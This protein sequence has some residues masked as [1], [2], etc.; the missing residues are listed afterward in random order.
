MMFTSVSLQFRTQHQGLQKRAKDNGGSQW[1]PHLMSHSQYPTVSVAHIWE[2]GCRYC[3]ITA[4][5]VPGK[6]N[7]HWKLVIKSPDP[8]PC[9]V[10]SGIHIKGKLL[11]VHHEEANVMIINQMICEAQKTCESIWYLSWVHTWSQLMCPA[12]QCTLKPHMLGT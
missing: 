2:Q 1:L 5:S 11:T 8:I 12:L 6:K 10:S 4:G 9:E 3:Q 7:N